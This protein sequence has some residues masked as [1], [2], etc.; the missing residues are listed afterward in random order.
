MIYSDMACGLG[1]QMF[2]FA[3]GFSLSVDMGVEYQVCLDFM[4]HTTSHNGYQLGLVVLDLPRV[5][6]QSDLVRAF[7]WLGYRR[8]RREVSR[9]PRWAH[10]FKSAVFQNGMPYRADVLPHGNTRPYLLH[11][12]WQTERYFVHNRSALIKAF[13]FAP[14]DA[15]DTGL[16]GRI[17]DSQ[18]VAIHIR[19]GDYLLQKNQNLFAVLDRSYY[20]RAIDVI[21]E[22]VATPKFFVFT[23]DPETARARLPEGLEYELVTGNSGLDSYLDMQLMSQCKHNI[24]ANSTFSWWGAWLNDDPDKIVVAP[25]EWFHELSGHDDRDVVPE[26]WTKVSSSE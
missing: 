8:F 7:G 3:R 12:N 13:N 2:Q 6:D 1:N 24:I 15:L 25:Q 18:S 23:D 14:S 4:P 17:R 11:G 26:S 21:Q 5:A 16:S 9:R 20:R 22:S 19:G 10:W